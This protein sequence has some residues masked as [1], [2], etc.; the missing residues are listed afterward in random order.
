VNGVAVLADVFECI[1]EFDLLVII[2]MR[3]IGDGRN[4]LSFSAYSLPE[5]PVIELATIGLPGGVI[6]ILYIDKNGNSFHGEACNSYALALRC[7]LS[8]LRK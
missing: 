4:D 1:L 7:S 2:A 6:N 3:C 8:W 5:F